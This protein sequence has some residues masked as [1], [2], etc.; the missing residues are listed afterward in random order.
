[1]IDHPSAK[2]DK[3][4]EFLPGPDFPTGAIIQ[5]KDEIRKAYETGKGRVVVRSRTEIEQLKGGKKQI[6]VTE[7]P[8]DVNKAVLVKKLMIFESI[9]RFQALQKFVMS[10]TVQACVLLSNLRRMLTAKP[11]LTTFEIYGSAGQLQFQY[12]GY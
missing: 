3:L 2:L 12:G 5:G 7:I 11:F 10:L 8:Y 1:M 6:I 9:T 4:M